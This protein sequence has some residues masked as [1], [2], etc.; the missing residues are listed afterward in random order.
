MADKSNNDNHESKISQ[1]YDDKTVFITGATGFMG[2]VKSVQKDDFKILGNLFQVL[3]EKLL[4]S[5][6]VK[7]IYLLIR[8]KKGIETKVRLEEL[9]SAKIFDKLKESSPDVM[10]R[11]EAINGDITEPSFGI[12]KE[13][14]R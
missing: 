10:S 6:R 7:K 13:D 3:V 2:K 12:R 9:M 8:P 1:F 4:R 11:V 5:T 14:E